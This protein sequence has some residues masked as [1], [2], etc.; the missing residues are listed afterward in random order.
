L[1]IHLGS[2]AKGPFYL[3]F[4]T[5]A[6]DASVSEALKDRQTFEGR[7]GVMPVAGKQGPLQAGPSFCDAE[8][9]AVHPMGPAMSG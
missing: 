1:P 9:A 8:A 2:T 7:P 3:I 6:P 5:Y 4:R